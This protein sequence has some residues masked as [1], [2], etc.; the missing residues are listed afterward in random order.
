MD[1]LGWPFSAQFLGIAQ[2]EK[3]IAEVAPLI[4]HRTLTRI[5]YI[6]AYMFEELWLLADYYL[7]CG[8]VLDAYESEFMKRDP[9]GEIT[10]LK[11]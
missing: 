8:R 9:C 5:C 11:A 10:A 1:R 6:S 2:L 4:S 3:K 7:K